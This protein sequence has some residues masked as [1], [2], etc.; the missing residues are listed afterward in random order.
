MGK[1]TDRNKRRRLQKNEF[2]KQVYL[3]RAAEP[4]PHELV[5]VLDNLKPDFNIGKILRSAAAFGLREVHI[6]GTPYFDPYPAKGAMKLVPLVFHRMYTTCL[7]QLLEADFQLYA[8]DLGSEQKIG[9]FPFAAKTALILGNEG[10][11]ITFD[12]KL[13]G[14]PAVSIP[15]FGKMDSLNVSVAASIAMYEYVRQQ[16]NGEL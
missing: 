3:N 15:Q 1:H 7:E 13:R 6:I 9:A 12:Y 4:G 8:L 5:L 11:G 2:Q 10:L 16:V 14:I